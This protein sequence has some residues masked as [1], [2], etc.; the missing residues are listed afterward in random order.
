MSGIMRGQGSRLLSILLPWSRAYCDEHKEKVFNLRHVGKYINYQPTLQSFWEF[1]PLPPCLPLVDLLVRTCVCFY[2]VTES[3][4]S[5]TSYP[6]KAA[7]C[8]L[9][10]ALMPYKEYCYYYLGTSVTVYAARVSTFG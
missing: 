10:I 2:I 6:R 8:W 1:F 9:V 4:K 7:L 5:R 3:R